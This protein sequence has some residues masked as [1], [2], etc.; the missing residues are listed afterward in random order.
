MIRRFM[1]VLCVLLAI[2]L[3]GCAAPRPLADVL[4]S[5]GAGE[6]AQATTQVRFLQQCKGSNYLS[7]AVTGEALDKLLQALRACEP[8]KA[9]E[10]PYSPQMDSDQQ[11]VLGDQ[12]LSLYV[13]AKHGLVV[14]L[15]TIA[16]K[17]GDELHAHYY[18]APEGLSDQMADLRK[19]A[20]LLQDTE[21]KPFRSIEELK[22]SIDADDLDEESEELDFEFYDGIAPEYKGTSCRLYDTSSAAA[23]TWDTV[24]ITA[25]GKSKTGEQVK[26]SITGLEANPYYTKVLVSQPDEAL[27]SVDTGDAPTANAAL[28]RRSAVNWDK[29]MVFVDEDGNLLDVIVPEDVLAPLPAGY[30]P[31]P[32]PTAAPGDDEGP[33]DGEEGSGD[34]GDNEEG[35]QD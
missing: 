4:T 23:L 33:G 18:A 17:K 31:E 16:T 15:E 5:F 27:D 24:L 12:G 13:S 9:P 3:A 11:I 1:P 29:W 26:L 7:A 10:E 20:K 35:A 32:A 6:G 19:G 28:V 30:S 21:V 25:Y 8:A 34:E 22:A 14:W 2:L